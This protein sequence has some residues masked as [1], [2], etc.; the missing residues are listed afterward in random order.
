MINQITKL[1]PQ[2][3]ICI[4]QAPFSTSPNDSELPRKQNKME[5]LQDLY[6]SAEGQTFNGK[7]V[8][9][10]QMQEKEWTV[11]EIT[12]EGAG[13]EQILNA[14]YEAVGEGQVWRG[15]TGPPQ[16]T[17]YWLW[18]DLK[19]AHVGTTR[20][21]C[22]TRYEGPFPLPGGDYE[23]QEGYCFVVE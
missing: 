13:L 7:V 3:K 6:Q 9:Y 12:G 20:Q 15:F 4:K 22:V 16:Y 14:I 18:V 21:F 19:N 5:N 8:C 1:S 17:N 2:F 23:C 10:Q 11:I